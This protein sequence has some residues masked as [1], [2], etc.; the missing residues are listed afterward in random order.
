MIEND[1]LKLGIDLAVTIIAFL[2]GRYILPK[3]KSTIQ[4]YAAEFAVILSYAESFV[5][6]ARQFL[7]DYT[8]EQKMNTVIE[9]LKKICEK[10]GIDVDEKTLKAIAQKAYDAMK[11]G[12]NNSSKII[13]ET[14]IEG[15]KSLEPITEYE[16]VEI[17]VDPFDHDDIK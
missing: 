12:E 7:T 8:G 15:L 5:A 6:Y 4:Q 1:I 16:N 14:A 11:A 3:Y 2:V 17:P 13:I 10:Q 9:E